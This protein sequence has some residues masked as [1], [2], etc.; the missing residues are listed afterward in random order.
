MDVLL[1]VARAASQQPE[2]PAHIWRDKIL[3][4]GALWDQSGRLA[5]LLSEL[6]PGSP[7]VVHGH[8]QGLML[9]CFLACVRAGHP[10]VPVDSS[11]PGGRLADIITASGAALVMAVDALDADSGVRE[12]GRAEIESAASDV[13]IAAIDPTLAVGPDEPFYIIYTSGSTGTPKGV[14]ISRLA[15]ERFATWALSLLTVRSTGAACSGDVYLNQAPFSFDLSVFE[16]ASTWSAGATMRS[17]DKQHIAKLATLFDELDG[18]DLT[19]WVSTPSFADLCL[20]DARFNADLLPRLSLFLFC[21]ETLANE[22]ARQLRERFPAATVVN[23][24]GPTES[25]VAVTSIICTDEVI[26]QHPVLPVGRAKPGTRLLI[27]DEEGRIL[28]DGE[29]G[30][31][32]IVGDTVSLGY[33]RRPDLSA[34]AFESID[35]ERAYRTGDSG[36]LRDG[37]LYFGG[38]MDFQVKLHGYRIELEDIEA[39][40]RQAV[41]VRHA[42]VLPVERPGVPGVVQYLRAFVQLDGPLPESPLK[43]MIALKRELADLLPDYMIPRVITFVESIPLTGNGKADRRALM[44]QH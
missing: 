28:P 12:L 2:R 4:Y 20:A 6:E 18:A 1:G 13:S 15:L 39:N 23:T 22:T 8:K 35:G 10:Y 21:G 43:R 29:L 11:V 24:Y 38:R 17:V 31:I 32:V 27:R 25:T 41:G 36:Q 14:Q 19:V 26:A 16:L 37:M 30:E 5:T 3:T 7:V 42:V 44:A 33:H 34:A 40:L 9:V